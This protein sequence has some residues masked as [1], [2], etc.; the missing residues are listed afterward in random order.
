ML[1]SVEHSS[2]KQQA[3]RREGGKETRSEKR[4]KKG[5]QKRWG[6]TGREEKRRRQRWR[7]WEHM[8]YV[9]RN[10]AGPWCYRGASFGGSQCLIKLQY[11][12]SF[13]LLC[14]VTFPSLLGARETGPCTVL[15]HYLRRNPLL[16]QVCPTSVYCSSVSL[17]YTLRSVL[18]PSQ[19]N[20]A[21]MGSGLVYANINNPPY[22]SKGMEKQRLRNGLLCY[23]RSTHLRSA[24]TNVDTKI[25]WIK[26]T[27]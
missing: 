1:S 3:D 15:L 2:I 10:I 22:S 8:E 11:R 13:S 16:L 18:G 19:S 4:R 14:H 12:L 6:E 26:A 25:V 9:Y 23:W 7:N 27:A 21:M 24:V 20:K 5:N 17:L